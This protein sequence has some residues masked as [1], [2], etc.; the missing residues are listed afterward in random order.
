MLGSSNVLDMAI[1]FLLPV[2]IA[3]QYSEGDFGIY[4]AIWLVAGTAAAVAPWGIPAS[5]YYFL[6]RH[7]PGQQRVYIWQTATLMACAG[8]LTSMLLVLLQCFGW[9]KLPRPDVQILF[10]GLWVLSTML[11]VLCS[12]LQRVQ[13][14]AT[15]NFVSSFLRLGLIGGIAWLSQSIEW[16]LM[17][18]L[19]FV[20]LRIAMLAGTVA[21]IR[22]DKTVQTHPQWKWSEQMGYAMPFGTSA[23]LY[24]LRTKMDQWIVVN[25]F[26]TAIYGIYSVASFFAPIQGLLRNTI[27]SL[28]LPR[29][30]R[31]HEDND[32]QGIIDINRK[33]NVA[34][35][36]LMFPV[37]AFV[38][39][40]SELIVSTIFGAPFSMAAHVVRIYMLTLAVECI[41][42]TTL[43]VAFK[44]GPF[45]MRVDAVM[46]VVCITAGWLGARHFGL[47]GAALGA[48]AGSAL[49]QLAL[50]TRFCR[51][52]SIRLANLQAWRP[53]ASLL[54]A[55]VMAATASK[56]AIV[57]AT[58]QHITLLTSALLFTATYIVL[59]R[60]SSARAM[61]VDTFGEKISRLLM[62]K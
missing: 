14:Q 8:L 25:T 12:A 19:V 17:A 34:M 56:G 6:P 53:M 30:N 55:S 5:L 20:G 58:S 46:L 51:I 44:Q 47:P 21:S 43:L 16:L 23:A 13:Q 18:H 29:I 54:G 2:F 62:L 22:G 32:H 52:S 35:V 7:S 40:W 42:V 57:L 27:S 33:A 28:T 15:I 3:R 61:L 37:L 4:R 48:L 60:S 1:Q 41:E 10:A 59:L 49:A 36:A 38:F 9:L 31:L 50:F 24:G 45:L 11:D 26:S 39:A